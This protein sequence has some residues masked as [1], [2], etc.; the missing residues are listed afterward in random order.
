[1]LQDQVYDAGN[2]LS[3]LRTR[4]QPTADRLQPQ[5]DDLRDDVIYLRVKLRR[6]GAVSRADYNDVRSK[7][8]GLRAEARGEATRAAKPAPPPPPPTPPP[9]PAG[10]QR[11]VAPGGPKSAGTPPQTTPRHGEVPVGTQLDARL[12]RELSSSTA[13]VEDRFTATTVVDLYSG[14]E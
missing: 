1:R 14:S 13:Q 8:E 9:P 4:D 12:E 7:I 6:E 10:A 2:E 3:R 11:P 5:L